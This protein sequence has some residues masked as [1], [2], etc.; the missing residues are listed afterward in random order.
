MQMMAVPVIPRACLRGS[1]IISAYSG[2]AA[3]VTR[4]YEQ[5]KWWI[6]YASLSYA[7]LPTCQYRRKA[8]Q[9]S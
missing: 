3:G 4:R 7:L 9:C 5:T 2:L 6:R 8:Y 1:Y